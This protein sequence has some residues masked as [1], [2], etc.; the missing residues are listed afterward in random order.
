MLSINTVYMYYNYIMA[1]RTSCDGA[2]ETKTYIHRP[3]EGV[4]EK[5]FQEKVPLK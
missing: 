1:W 4:R 2:A 3:T 5:G